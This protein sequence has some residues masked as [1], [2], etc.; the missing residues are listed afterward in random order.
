[1]KSDGEVGLAE[2][3]VIAEYASSSLVI[4]V[5]GRGYKPTRLVR[6]RS[7][8]WGSRWEE[9]DDAWSGFTVV[10]DADM[11]IDECVSLSVTIVV[12]YS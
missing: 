7:S 10:A 1:M 9:E 4:F 5:V 3:V 6:M 11:D 2:P 8:R 12:Q